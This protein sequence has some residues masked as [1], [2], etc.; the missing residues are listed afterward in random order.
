MILCLMEC[1][2]ISRNGL[3]SFYFLQSYRSF[4]R[5]FT[6]LENINDYSYIFSDPKATL[7]SS[8]FGL[9]YPHT[10]TWLLYHKCD[11]L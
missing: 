1:L 6:Q 5:V 2:Q 8:T 10:S 4:S 3:S 11:G 7:E 9:K